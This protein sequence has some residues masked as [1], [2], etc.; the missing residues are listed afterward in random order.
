MGQKKCAGKA[1]L[2]GGSESGDIFCSLWG[3]CQIMISRIVWE[4]RKEKRGIRMHYNDSSSQYSMQDLTDIILHPG[5]SSSVDSEVYLR[6]VSLENSLIELTSADS[7][8]KF[9][10]CWFHKKMPP[11][12]HTHTAASLSQR[13]FAFAVFGLLSEFPSNKKRRAAAT[14]QCRSISRSSAELISFRNALAHTEEADSERA[15]INTLPI[16][17]WKVGIC[18]KTFSGTHVMEGGAHFI[19]DGTNSCIQL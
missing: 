15:W 5:G 4:Y 7:A 9:N 1:D 14:D 11:A 13:S 8:L 6:S 10:K 3:F 2:G 16:S 19:R 12:P 17:M 18:H